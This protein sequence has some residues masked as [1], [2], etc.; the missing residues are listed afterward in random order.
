VACVAGSVRR[1]PDHRHGRWG[2]PVPRVV[3]IRTPHHASGCATGTPWMGAST[4]F[5]WRSG[6]SMSCAAP[7]HEYWRDTADTTHLQWWT[8]RGSRRAK[9]IPP[10]PRTIAAGEMYR[11]PRLA[12][13]RGRP[14]GGPV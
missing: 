1:Q 2:S 5:S 12:I 14:R 10:S 7:G 3:S 9:H 4:S 13:E 11:V 6:S 8:A